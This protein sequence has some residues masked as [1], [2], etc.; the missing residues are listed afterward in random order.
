MKRYHY[1]QLISGILFFLML[2]FVLFVSE[3]IL[4]LGMLGL[5]ATGFT[6]V[7]LANKAGD[8]KKAEKDEAF[9]NGQLKIYENMHAILTDPVSGKSIWVKAKTERSD[10]SCERLVWVDRKGNAYGQCD[11]SNEYEVEFL[12][13]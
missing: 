12:D 1:Y 10:N 2:F 5:V 13:D 3:R 6:S 4:W 9:R 7:F 8:M 11:P